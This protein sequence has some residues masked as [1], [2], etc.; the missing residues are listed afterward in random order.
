MSDSGKQQGTA[1]CFRRKMV[2]LPTSQNLQGRCPRLWCSVVCDCGAEG[3]SQSSQES[4]ILA[5]FVG[6][7]GWDNDCDARCAMYGF[8]ALMG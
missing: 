7:L 8:V 3:H 1:A 4:G 5:D 6:F 2:S